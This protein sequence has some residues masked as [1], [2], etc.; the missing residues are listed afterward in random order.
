MK[1]VKAPDALKRLTGLMGTSAFLGGNA[2]LKNGPLHRLYPNLFIM[3]IANPGNGKSLISN[4]V[5]DI[6]RQYNGIY[7]D[8][9]GMRQFMGPKKL[10]PAAFTELLCSQNRDIIINGKEE[11]VTPCFLPSSELAVLVESAQHGNMLTD[12]LDYYDCPPVFDKYTRMNEM[13]TI[14]RPVI[15]MIMSTTPSFWNNFMPSNLAQDGFS[16]RTLLYQFNEFIWREANIQ[17][18]SYEDLNLCIEDAYRLKNLTGVFELSLEAKRWIEGPF[19]D[20]NNQL[21]FKHFNGNDLWQG[22]TNRRMDQMKKIAMCLSAAESNDL[23]VS[24]EHCKQSVAHLEIIEAGMSG[25]IQ[26]KDARFDTNLAP[27]IEK[28]L[29][30]GP[31][32]LQ[33]LVGAIIRSGTVPKMPALLSTL[34]AYVTGGLFIHDGN[35]KYRKAE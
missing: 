11:I 29:S 28:L 18:G 35:G 31:M 15:S 26:R 22:Y 8:L 6:V 33:D 34:D 3:I 32:S 17:W 12:L 2:Y 14:Y 5:S 10:N 4:T 19:N 30:N 9:P 7:G 24:L 16:S 1:N 21:M 20:D 25:L 23:V 27:L 13:E